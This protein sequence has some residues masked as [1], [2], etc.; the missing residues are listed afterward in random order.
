MKSVDV[1]LTH[2]LVVTMNGEREILEDGAVAISGNKIVSVGLT[3]LLETQVS[4][5]RVINMKGKMVLP[6]FI[7]AHSHTVL[8]V[9]R[10]VAEDKGD[11]ALYGIMAPTN[12][13][14]NENREMIYSLSTLGFSELVKFGSTTV[15]ENHRHMAHIAPAAVDIGVR[16]VLSEISNDAD[17]PKIFY[18]EYHYSPTI[19]DESLQ[20]AIDL[21]E[22]WN[23]KAGGRI[24]CQLSPHAPDTCSPE[25]LRRIGEEARRLNVGMTAHVGQKKIETE[26]VKKMWGCGSV[27]AL[28]EAGILGP[29]FIGAHCVLITPEEVELMAKTGATISHNPA[30]NAKR[31]NIAPAVEFRELGGNVAIGTD[32]MH[33]NIIEAMKL[34]VHCARVRTGDGTKWQPMDMLEMLTVNGAKAIGM[35]DKLGSIEEDKIA[36]I[37]A[38]DL[39]KPHLY[40]L[41]NPVGS[42]VHNAIGSD[43]RWVM[44]DGKI[45]VDDGKL[46]TVD[47]EQVLREAQ[48]AADFTWKELRKYPLPN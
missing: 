48:K 20:R 43:V 35:E 13:I 26:Q 34:G 37:I 16:A 19:G 38:I 42:F 3:K 2:G 22:N 1:L 7:N 25:F 11:Q 12:K 14:L 44:I 39:Q 27:E 23:G 24:T 31:G 17:L 8:T 45:V 47:E 18:G 29:D 30:I 32:N 5:K 41:V 21:V 46:Q 4:A 6:G 36:D 15:V 9:L 10:G 28:A 40:P 33:G